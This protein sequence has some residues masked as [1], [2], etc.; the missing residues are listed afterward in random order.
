[1][2]LDELPEEICTRIARFVTRGSQNDNGLCLAHTSPK[3]SKA[4]VSTLSHK[5]VFDCDEK[6][7]VLQWIKLLSNNVREVNCHCDLCILP[8]FQ[9]G[10]RRR[11]LELLGA[12]TLQTAEVSADKHTLLAIKKSVSLRKLHV[13]L[14]PD[15]SSGLILETLESLKLE[16]LTLECNGFSEENCAFVHI[17]CFSEN[18][19]ALSECLSELSAL[20]VRCHCEGCDNPI[21]R[22]LPMLPSLR[23][24]RLVSEPPDNALHTLQSLD[25]VQISH[26]RHGKHLAIQLG[27][28]VTKLY[29]QDEAL[30]SDDVTNLRNC[31][32]IVDLSVIIADGAEL[33]LLDTM[34][35][36]RYLHSL[37]LMFEMSVFN[38]YPRY[39]EPAPGI[40]MNI[41]CGLHSLETLSLP[42]MRLELS[43]LN[44]ILKNV[45]PRLKSFKT[46]C[47]GQE[48]TKLGRLEALLS[49]AIRNN[50]GLQNFV[51]KDW[52]SDMPLEV[53]AQLGAGEEE[54]LR[55]LRLLVRLLMEHAPLLNGSYLEDVVGGGTF[56]ENGEG[57]A[58]ESW[59]DKDPGA[60][61]LC[62]AICIGCTIACVPAA[63][64]LVANSGWRACKWAG[65]AIRSSWKV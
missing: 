9:Y 29:V 6:R 52:L 63:L 48:E 28:K 12:P 54:Q 26:I 18:N 61:M 59:W 46:S 15:Y 53:E 65:K 19:V 40:M 31:P 36:I 45:G 22:F 44:C 17:P 5:L 64:F 16:D 27:A 34:S 14:Y 13:H 55:R 20:E 51:L 38:S 39:Y 8:P 37:E 47:D 43:E 1:M 24:V 7:Q 50:S 35:S 23:E 62:C 57:G 33:L 49:I 30:D 25:A 11:L 41:V 32:N 58:R 21:W 10:Y 3:Q 60:C 56:S 4:V 2:W 42:C